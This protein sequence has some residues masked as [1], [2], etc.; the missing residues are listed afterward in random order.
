MAYA[1]MDR[2]RIYFI[3]TASSLSYGRAYSRVRWSQQEQDDEH[4]GQVNN[5]E[6]VREDL[7]VAQPKCLE[8]YYN[9]CA[10]IYQHNLHRQDTLCIE[11]RI[12]NKKWDKIVT[13]Y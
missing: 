10:A 12:E 11:L 9:I 4:F 2:D 7:V 13:T 3:S 1:W 6:A 5:E 8:I